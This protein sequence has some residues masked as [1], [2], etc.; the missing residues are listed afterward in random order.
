MK[1]LRLL[2]IVTFLA[3]V[4]FNTLSIVDIVFNTLALLL[5][6]YITTRFSFVNHLGKYLVLLSFWISLMLMPAFHLVKSLQG[7]TSV[8]GYTILDRDYER[9]LS[10]G[11]KILLLTS[12]SWLFFAVF[13]EKHKFRTFSYK[14]KPITSKTIWLIF[15]FMYGLSIFSM[16]IGLSRMGGTEVQLPFHLSGII[17]LLRVTF[18]PFFA[19]TIAENYIMRKKIIPK[20]FII[21][22]VIWGLLEVFVRLSKAALVLSL[23]PSIVIMFIYYRPSLNKIIRVSAP[24]IIMFLLLY[25]IVETMR[26]QD[27]KSG[28]VNS[29]KLAST[30]LKGEEI[31]YFLQPLN[32]TFMTPAIFAK[33]YEFVNHSSFFDF[34]KA[35]LLIAVGGS[36]RYQTI[37]IDG[38]PEDAH[39]SS[40][41]TGLEDA[42]LFGG[43][44]FCY[45]IVVL[46]MLF[47]MYTDRIG[48]KRKF[49]IYVVLMMMLW[50]YCNT[51]TVSTLF[52]SVGL[53]YL[54]FRIL[55]IIVSYIINFKQEKTIAN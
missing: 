10:F 7:V 45:I 53:Q 27:T 55:S 5:M 48:R 12:L 51:G 26:S 22:F 3:A 4:L 28:I 17:T 32:R 31:S 15:A 47:A 50:G 54:F 43:Y 9:I 38:Y 39:H 13:S 52:G 33:D 30:E 41:T 36:A 1:G 2:F 18:F 40:G 46:I 20:K 25:P 37:I 16:S 8:Y 49:T 23:I 44:G 19:A 21:L 24:L 42:L 29:F 6:L 35:P 34:S 11:A 14:A